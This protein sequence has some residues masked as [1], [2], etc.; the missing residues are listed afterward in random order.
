MTIWKF[1]FGLSDIVPIAMPK[2]AKP[3]HVEEQHGQACL[4]ALVDESAPTEVREFRVV[5]TGHPLDDE[6]LGA[7]HVGTFQASGGAFVWHV[8]DFCKEPQNAT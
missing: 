7:R 2:G 3:L 1:P 8:F 6:F 4:W 5:G